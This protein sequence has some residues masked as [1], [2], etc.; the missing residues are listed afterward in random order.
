MRY[1]KEMIKIVSTAG[2]TT[3]DAFEKEVSVDKSDI[4]RFYKVCSEVHPFVI[5]LNLNE[6]DP[7]N[8]SLFKKEDLNSPVVFPFSK[9][10]IEFLNQWF[11]SLFDNKPTGLSIGCCVL[12]EYGP[13]KYESYF[14]INYGGV[15][16]VVYIKRSGM[17][18]TTAFGEFLVTCLHAINNGKTG[19]EKS[20]ERIVT[21][22]NGVKTITKINRIIH[23][24]SK[25]TFKEYSESNRHIDFSH[26]FAVRGHWRIKE[27]GLG[28]DRNGDY[29]INGFTWVNECEKGP[30]DLP[31]IRKT[32]VFESAKELT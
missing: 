1:F 28:K 31:L 15:D 14:L 16:R 3:F 7:I 27:G 2:M 25:K 9:F 12:S 20:N 24:T 4:E 30:E 23:V 5:N 13:N 17:I 8:N 18:P 10:S 11:G 32:R 6:G 22:T 21:R 26:R 19:I 29:C